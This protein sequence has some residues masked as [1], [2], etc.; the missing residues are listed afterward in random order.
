MTGLATG[1]HLHFELRLNGVPR[2][3]LKIIPPRAAPVKR[4]YLA[5]FQARADSLAALLQA[6]PAA[7][8]DSLS[9]PDSS[10]TASGSQ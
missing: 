2:N 3:P 1:P 6:A 9:E 4:E 10:S 5:Q 8:A 7:A